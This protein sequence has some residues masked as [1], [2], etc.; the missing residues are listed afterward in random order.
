MSE[1]LTDKGE[2]YNEAVARFE[3]MIDEKGNFF[4]DF[5]A[6]EFIIHHY[7]DSGNTAKALLACNHAL[8][9]YPFSATIN[10][11]K[12]KILA[13][14]GQAEEALACIEAA[15][16]LQPYD[17]EIKFVKAS[18][19]QLRKEYEKALTYY[20]QLLDEGEEKALVYY[21]I[22]CAYYQLKKNQEAYRYLK[23]SLQ[24]EPNEPTVLNLLLDS[25]I[26]KQETQQLV[27]MF[28]QMIDKKPYN[29]QLWYYL[30][31]VYNDLLQFDDALHA[32]DYATV[33]DDNFY[34]AHFATGHVYMNLK[35]YQDAYQHY[36]TAWTLNR[37]GVEINC[38]LGA[39]LEKME[40]FENAINYYR[41]ATQLDSSCAEAWFGMGVCLM[42][43]DKWY[44]AI[45]FF[46]RAA[47][48]DKE[49][50]SYWV[51]LA[52]SEY[53]TGNVIS[54]IEA[55][56]QAVAISPQ[57]P[58]V[59]LNWSFIHYEQGEIDA[60]IDL[61]MEGLEDM[62]DNS[63]MQYRV[64]CYLIAAGQYQEAVKFLE[65]ALALN[66][67]QHTILFEFFPRAEVQRA[68][69]KLINQFKP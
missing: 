25:C 50:A 21:H 26:T 60:A 15:E 18:I 40:M 14:K 54:S 55:Y 4:F 22:G 20:H 24:L 53:K 67:E 47:K 57:Q 61:V 1:E 59:W 29:K 49:N 41:K 65:L 6:I 27:E 46:K 38:H 17:N 12:A 36:K 44:E 10:L 35:K 11:E 45:H 34:D 9:L 32:L 5:N 48:L 28:E 8:A 2:N 69:Q 42:S 3:Q 66:Y 13:G 56:K 37:E 31:I 51:A 63:E 43:K 58:D 39:C 64:V 19:F 33:I 62:P 30:G 16:L 68:L 52:E 23:K 7:I